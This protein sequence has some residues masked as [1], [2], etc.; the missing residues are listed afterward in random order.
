MIID[1]TTLHEGVTMNTTTA[2][3]NIDQ[4]ERMYWQLYDR[5]N[6]HNGSED[7]K[8]TY[9]KLYCIIEQ[10]NKELHS[11]A[12]L[13][14]E[15]LEDAERNAASIKTSFKVAISNIAGMRNYVDTAYEM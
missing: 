10:L 9:W 6:W 3:T 1:N 12:V 13:C 7:E 8:K 5:T 2:L 15:S 4:L 14:C 11:I